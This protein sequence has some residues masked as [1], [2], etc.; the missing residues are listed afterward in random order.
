MLLLLLWIVVVV[1]V[2]VTHILFVF[3]SFTNKRQQSPIK[4]DSTHSLIL[5][6]QSISRHFSF[7]HTLVT[8]FS[9][10]R[11]SFQLMLFIWT[12]ILREF[13]FGIFFLHERVSCLRSVGVFV[14]K[15]EYSFALVLSLPKNEC[16]NISI[17]QMKRPFHGATK[18]IMSKNWKPKYNLFHSFVSYK[19][20]MRM[21]GKFVYTL[22][23]FYLSFICAQKKWQKRISIQW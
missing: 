18:R 14:S 2:S 20:L 19:I 3:S 4:N 13:D 15:M 7:S 8:S 21:N 9:V 5:L 10:V 1:V 12:L 11:C 23:E 6:N 17:Y 16:V 22:C